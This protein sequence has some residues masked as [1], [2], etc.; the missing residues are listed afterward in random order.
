MSLCPVQLLEA[1][2]DLA[3]SFLSSGI[4]TKSC[5]GEIP[6]VD[7]RKESKGQRKRHFPSLPQPVSSI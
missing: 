3:L 2:T 7:P 1:G 5:S 4:T 6:P